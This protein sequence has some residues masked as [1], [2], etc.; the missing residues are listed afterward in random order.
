M[1]RILR[2]YCRAHASLTS[3]R[4]RDAATR[5]PDCRARWLSAIE[6][7]AP[8]DRAPR[9]FRSAVPLRRVFP[10]RAPPVR[11]TVRRDTPVAASSPR[12]GIARSSAA[13]SLWR[14]SSPSVCPSRIRASALLSAARARVSR[15]NCSGPIELSRP[16]IDLGEPTSH[17]DFG[18][19][20]VIRAQVLH[21]SLDSRRCVHLVQIR[22]VKKWEKFVGKIS[23]A[24][25]RWSGSSERRP[26]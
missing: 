19:R 26:S 25:S 4:N 23:F 21:R 12:R 1:G 16:G 8:S 20:L 10:A 2:R 15:R 9:R 14:P 24:F 13:A 22:A 17:L 5:L 7:T 11:E 3:S 18:A 6:V